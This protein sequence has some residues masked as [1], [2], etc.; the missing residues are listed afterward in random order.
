MQ[1]FRKLKLFGL[2]GILVVA[3]AFIGMN[4]VQAQVK[5][6]RGKPPKPPKEEVNW[7]V[8]IPETS[9]MLY[10]ISPDYTYV[11]ND[12]TTQN[13]PDQITKDNADKI[14]KSRNA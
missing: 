10:G 14:R 3:L 13:I 4:F 9:I 12:N 1:K 2:M 6:T 11:N 5:T 8:R 7:E